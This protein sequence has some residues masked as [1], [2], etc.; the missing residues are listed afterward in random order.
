MPPAR[1]MR[2]ARARNLSS[3]TTNFLRESMASSRI[4]SSSDRRCSASLRVNS[5]CPSS[6]MSLENFLAADVNHGSG[7]RNKI[8]FVDAVARFLLIHD[9]ADGR[10]DFVVE[11]AAAQQRLQ[12]VIFLAEKAGA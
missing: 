1:R 6:P 10:S 2:S 12:V 7:W 5:F 8:R 9:R 4:G 3:N 11:G